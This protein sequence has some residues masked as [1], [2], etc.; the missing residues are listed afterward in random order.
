MRPGAARDERD[1]EG[2]LVPGSDA[3]RVLR[4]AKERRP[5]FSADAV[6]P[7]RRA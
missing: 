5:T 2:L 3:C 4:A 7:F 1:R 6:V